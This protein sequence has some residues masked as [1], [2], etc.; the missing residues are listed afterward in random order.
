MRLLKPRWI[1]VEVANSDAKVIDG[2]WGGD[3]GLRSVTQYRVPAQIEIDP[4]HEYNK[5]NQIVKSYAGKLV[6]RIAGSEWMPHLGDR[7]IEANNQSVDWY[8]EK[9]TVNEAGGYAMIYY[10]D[11]ALRQG[12]VNAG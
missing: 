2:V 10:Q 5:L 6:I 3:G 8:V 12:V 11:R 9:V 7:I 4:I 1:T